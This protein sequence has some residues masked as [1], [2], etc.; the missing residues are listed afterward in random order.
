MHGQPHIRFTFHILP[1]PF[2]RGS[3]INFNILKTVSLTLNSLKWRIWWA[4]NN[5][6][7]WQLG[8]NSAFKGL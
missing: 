4:P 7:R 3:T 6:C 8:F 1:M 2:I 5:G